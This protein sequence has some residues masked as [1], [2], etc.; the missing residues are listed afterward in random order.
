M[1]SWRDIAVDWLYAQ[2]EVPNLF[3]TSGTFCD[4]PSSERCILSRLFACLIPQLI[5]DHLSKFFSN[6]ISGDF[7]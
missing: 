6:L 1:A 7:A 3:H 5:F 4:L 2:R